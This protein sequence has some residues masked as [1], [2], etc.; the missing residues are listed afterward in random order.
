M[1]QALRVLLATAETAAGP[2]LALPLEAAGFAPELHTAASAGDYVT[3]LAQSRTN[4]VLLHPPVQGLDLDAAIAALR[5]AHPRAPLVFLASGPDEAAARIVARPREEAVGLTGGDL[6][7]CLHSMDD[8][9]GCEMLVA[10][11]GQEALAH[12]DASDSQ[13]ALVFTDLIMPGIDGPALIRTLRQRHPALPILAVTGL[14]NDAKLSE[15]RANGAH[16]VLQKPCR[17]EQILWALQGLLHGQ[18]S[19]PAGQAVTRDTGNNEPQD[20]LNPAF[21][22]PPPSA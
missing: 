10:C 12:L 13:R 3:P 17:A 21:D 4:L 5:S 2:R 22:S 9:R 20:G 7:R 1:R 8:P 18:R 16:H 6:F 14:G 19:N 11:E 15:A